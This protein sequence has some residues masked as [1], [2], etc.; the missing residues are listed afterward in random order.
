VDPGQM[1]IG[2]AFYGRSWK[3]VTPANNGLHQTHNNI[4][5]AHSYTDLQQMIADDGNFK[6]FWDDKSSAPFIYNSVDSTF[7]T[8]DDPKSLALKTQYALEKG[9]GGIMFWQLSHDNRKNEL[10]NAIFEAKNRKP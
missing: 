7:I 3:G 4:K 1:V 5:G 2:A 8:L 9:L 10:V 6:R